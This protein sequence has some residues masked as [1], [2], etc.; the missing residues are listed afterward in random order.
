MHGFLLHLYWSAAEPMSTAIFGMQ[1]AH[2]CPRLR[3]ASKTTMKMS[4]LEMRQ[5][6]LNRLIDCHLVRPAMQIAHNSDPS[7]LPL[8]ELPH[9]SWANVFLLYC[10]F[11]HSQSQAPASRSTFFAISLRWRQCMRFH[12]QSQ[13]AI[14]LTCSTLKSR[15]KAARDPWLT[16]GL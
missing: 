4:G 14:C 6:M 9:G 12:K 8:R 1:G 13:H 10:S 11:C 7:Q 3:I 15:I 5:E 2:A 16:L